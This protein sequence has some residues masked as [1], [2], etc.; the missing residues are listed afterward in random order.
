MLKHVE[1]L[2]K[3]TYPILSHPIPSYPILSPCHVGDETF[4]T[5]LEGGEVLAHVDVDVSIETCDG[6]KHLA[7][8]AQLQGQSVPERLPSG[9][10]LQ[11]TMENH[12][13]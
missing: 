3:D 4:R 6:G 7:P 11:K 8:N 9:K 12:H 2:L 10:R 5:L 1:D 13:F